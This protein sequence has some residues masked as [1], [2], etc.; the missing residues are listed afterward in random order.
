[1]LTVFWDTWP[2]SL[3]HEIELT[4][5]SDAILVMDSLTNY[6]KFRLL[7]ELHG[8]PG[9]V[10]FAP[11]AVFTDVVRPTKTAKSRD[12]LMLGSNEGQ[13]IN[14]TRFLAAGLADRGVSMTRLGGLIDEENADEENAKNW[15]GW[16][17]YVA[18]INSTK[19]GLSSQTQPDRLQIKGKIF[20]YF[21]CGV[22][23]LADENPELREIV[24]PDC[25]AFYRDEADCLEKILYFLDHD[26][27]REAI[28]ARGLAWLN[29]VYDYKTFWRET[30]EHLTGKG[31]QFPVLPGVESGY[32]RYKSNLELVTRSSLFAFDQLG[33][34][35]IGGKPARRLPVRAEGVYKGLNILNIDERWTIA[36]DGVLIDFIEIDNALFVLAPGAGLIELPEGALHQTGMFRLVR[37]ESVAHAKNVIDIIGAK[38]NIN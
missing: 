20:D 18:A 14:L 28:A 23:C 34:A 25:L 26:D 27:E 36:C 11:I 1:M 7:A 6:F 17:D 29:G 22:F 32:A 30:V 31:D 13:R 15:I 21:A 8:R 10:A 35:V 3:P 19:I 16:E 12:V 5:N 38:E 4:L 9:T 37:A 24:P 2:D 33:R